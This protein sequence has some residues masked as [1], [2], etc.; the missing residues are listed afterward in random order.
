MFQFQSGAVKSVELVLS[1]EIDECFNSKVVRLKA[2][3]IIR[4]ESAK[5]MFQFQSGAV[6]RTT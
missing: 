1:G 6:K 2:I 5:K 4:K 3:G